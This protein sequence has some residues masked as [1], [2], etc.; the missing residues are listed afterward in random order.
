MKKQ[1]L[2]K[3]TFLFLFLSTAVN[4]QYVSTGNNGNNVTTEQYVTMSPTNSN[5]NRRNMIVYKDS[6]YY[7]THYPTFRFS[8]FGSAKNSGQPTSILWTNANGDLQ[9]S[10]ISELR[11]TRSQIT[12]EPQVT[13]GM[14][15]NVSQS[16]GDYEISVDTT[17]MMSQARAANSI[18]NIMQGV[19]QKAD[20]SSVYTKTQS[21]AKYKDINYNPT[22]AD[23]SGLQSQLN[24]KIGTG[25]WIDFSQI[26][27]FD[28]AT[29]STILG[30][31][32][33]HANGLITEYVTGSGA[34]MA[35][36]TIPSNTNQLTNGAGFITLENDPTVPN[37][38]K[39]LT[40]FSVIK[41]STDILY[42]DI[43]YEPSW[44]NIT[45]KPSTFAPSTHN[46]PIS[47]VNGLQGI[48]DSKQ[49]S[50]NYLTVEADPN[51]PSY[52]KTLVGF[53]TIKS[54]TDPLYRPI[55]YVPS[56]TEITGRPTTL[57]GFGITDG[58]S[59]SSLA[60]KQDT[61]VSGTNLKTVNGNNLL[62]SGNVIITATPSGT[63]GGDLTGS[64][65]NPTLTT[66]GVVAGTYGRVTVDSKGRI[67]AGKRQETYSGTTDASGNYTVTFSTAYSTTPNVQ[68]SITNQSSGNQFIRVSNVT[69]TGFTINV[70]QR[71]AV[72]LL[73]LEVLLAATANVSGAL[74]DVLISEK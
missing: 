27:G 72:T 9:K 37:Y 14:G 61:L 18:A 52:A 32:P 55:T 29:I 26:V 30:Y 73:G 42:K 22:I 36:P 58:A 39:S 43:A 46:H 35:F 59:V 74:V 15:I 38:A 4:A 49:A 2:L 17:V 54:S 67:T 44:N 10:P 23:V 16:G 13:E 51:V 28:S 19:N 11:I 56:W 41:A 57:V 47:E 63:A 31:I 66:T 71:N 1:L 60:A 48:L 21:D 68:A 50:G 34:I 45:G 6:T 33:F 53:S 70:F 3:L 69:T 5:P 62:G 12:D 8:R 25:D 40:G 65:P 24:G 7:Y 64:Y 20:A